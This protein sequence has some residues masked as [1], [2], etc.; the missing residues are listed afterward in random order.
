MITCCQKRSARRGF[1]NRCFIGRSV[2]EGKHL[3]FYFA[4]IDEDYKILSSRIVF[5]L[6]LLV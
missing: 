1:F 6:L 5:L 2:P 4:T 3:V